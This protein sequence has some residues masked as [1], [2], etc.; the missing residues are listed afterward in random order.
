MSKKIS[1]EE[2]AVRDADFK[3]RHLQ[4]DKELRALVSKYEVTLEAEPFIFKGLTVARPTIG[5]A[6]EYNDDDT[7]ATEEKVEGVEKVNDG[8]PT[9]EGEDKK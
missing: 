1:Q 3:S 5:D 2:K 4:F 7:P 8:A 9:M 6:K